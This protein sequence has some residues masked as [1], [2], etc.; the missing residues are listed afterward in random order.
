MKKSYRFLSMVLLL[1]IMT[2]VICPQATFADEKNT[3]VSG[4]FMKAT[5]KVIKK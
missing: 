4:L 5:M 2:V 1:L 3:S